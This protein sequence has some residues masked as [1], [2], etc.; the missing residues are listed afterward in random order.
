M[1]LPVGL[2]LHI[3][4]LHEERGLILIGLGVAGRE[5][6]PPWKAISG[7]RG[8]ARRAQGPELGPQPILDRA[9]DSG[10][11]PRGLCFRG[12]RRR[13]DSSGGEDR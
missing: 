2:D 4:E 12:G 13:Q 10:R 11:D 9:S 1:L 8:R 7:H 3:E 5:L 6:P